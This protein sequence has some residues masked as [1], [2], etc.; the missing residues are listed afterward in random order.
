MRAITVWTALKNIGSL[1][2]ALDFYEELLDRC[3]YEFICG[4]PSNYDVLRCG[5]DVYSALQYIHKR[6]GE[7]GHPIC[8]EFIEKV[9]SEPEAPA[10]IIHK[11]VL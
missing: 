4:E 9:L 3:H 5:Q 6:Q 2:A 7:T 11:G 1:T 8:Y 10:T